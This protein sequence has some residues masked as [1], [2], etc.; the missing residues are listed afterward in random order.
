MIATGEAH[1]LEEFVS[2]T[3]S[4]RSVSIGADH[5][6]VD[7]GVVPAVG[8]P[9]QQGKR[10]ESAL[11]AGVGGEICDGRRRAYDGRSRTRAGLAPLS[12]SFFAL[13][14]TRRG[15]GLSEGLSPDLQ[16][17]SQPF[18]TIKLS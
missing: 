17:S 8:N 9:S 18:R 4:L 13:R 6:A 1:S 3:P 5:V 2:C 11:K 14:R 12:S 7:P 15:C 16:L 10:G